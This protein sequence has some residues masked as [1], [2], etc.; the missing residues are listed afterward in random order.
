MLQ[1]S[2][3]MEKINYNFYENRT[4]LENKGHSYS[5]QVLHQMRN[6]TKLTT[7]HGKLIGVSV[8]PGDAELLTLKAVRIIQ[9]ASLI[10]YTVNGKGYS[11]AR[12][13]IKDYIQEGSE[14]LA[15]HFS[16]SEDGDVRKAARKEVAQQ[17]LSRLHAGQ[18]VVYIVEGDAL[19]YSTFIH[20]L[21]EMTPEIEIEIC[22]GVS[23]FNAA[24]AATQLPLDQQIALIP[25]YD[26]KYDIIE[27]RLNSFNTIAFYKVHACMS[28]VLF[29]LEATERLDQAMLIEYAS[30]KVER[31]RPISQYSLKE[32]LPYF[33]I[34]LVVHDKED[35]DTW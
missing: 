2:D 4:S 17:V 1:Y 33:S 32:Q 5:Y 24:A 10:A 21:E 25:A 18:D 27:E 16:M 13:I 28:K 3:V 15:L 29:A 9:K 31:I 8:G 26:I 7:P 11:Y 19:I 22:P 30:G 35:L 12:E 20:I 6:K 23:S 34:V 14:E